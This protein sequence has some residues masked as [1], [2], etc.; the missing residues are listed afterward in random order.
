MVRF[1]SG[2]GQAGMTLANSCDKDQHSKTGRQKPRAKC[3]GKGLCT[4]ALPYGYGTENSS[5]V[6]NAPSSNE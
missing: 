1:P 6:R 4:I 2:D 3:D 5:E